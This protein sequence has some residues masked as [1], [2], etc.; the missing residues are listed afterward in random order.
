MRNHQRALGLPVLSLLLSAALL[1]ACSSNSPQLT[2]AAA[3]V[4]GA[5]GA[6]D[7]A[8]SSRPVA[9]AEHLNPNSLIATQRS[10]YFDFDSFEVK[11][12]DAKTVE[13]HGRYLAG[14]PDLKVRI[15]G[16]TDERGGSEYNLALGQKRAE[17]VARALRVYGVREEQTESVSFG[18]ERPKATG[19]DEESWAQNRRAD[20]AYP[21]R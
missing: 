10:V 15:E 9:R 16:H 6:Q 20:I 5:G 13:L 3:P 17:A 18:K 8:G 1:G 21:E 19:H 12:E 2:A 14:A 7:A 11:G 4:A